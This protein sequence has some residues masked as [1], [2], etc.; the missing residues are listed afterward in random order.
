LVGRHQPVPRDVGAERLPPD[1]TA[2]RRLCRQSLVPTNR[3]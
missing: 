3:S 1:P 2:L